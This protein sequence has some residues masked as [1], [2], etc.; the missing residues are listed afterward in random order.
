MLVNVAFTI[1]FAVILASFFYIVSIWIVASINGV[2]VEKV[3]SCYI[4]VYTKVVNRIEINLG[5]IPTGSSIKLSGIID[6]SLEENNPDE[7]K[8]YDFRRKSAL[9]RTMILSLSF[10]TPFIIGLLLLFSSTALSLIEMASTYLLIALFQAPLNSG[11]QIWELLYTNSFFLI[12]FTM[13]LMAISSLASTLY[14]LNS[15]N[16]ATQLLKVI[17]IT[18]LYLFI[19]SLWIVLIRLEWTNFEILH[20]PFFFLG[21]ILTGGICLAFYIFLAKKLPNP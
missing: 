1:G 8:P 14:H 15:V 2:R 9:Q 16:F 20:I 21:G 3:E 6:E 10:L 17:I 7:I 11:N 18:A 13:L 4:E 5:V 12:G 19:F